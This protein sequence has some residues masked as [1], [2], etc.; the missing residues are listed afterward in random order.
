MRTAL[1]RLPHVSL[2]A[3]SLVLA[4]GG[5][6]NAK[7]DWQIGHGPFVSASDVRP[8]NKMPLDIRDVNAALAAEQ[9]DWRAAL[10]SFAFGGNFANHSLAIFTDN[11]NNRFPQHLPVS[12]GHFGDPGFQNHVLTAAIVGTGKFR[13]VEPAERVAFIEAGL[14]AVTINWSRYELGES[15][16]K[17][18]AAE[19]NWSLEN[20]SPKNWNEIFA[21]Y[22]GPEGEHSAH[23]AVERREGGA[24]INEALLQALADGQE[25]LVTESWTPEHAE[26]VARHLNEASVL[27][28]ADA[29]KQ[30]LDAGEGESAVARARAAGYWLAAAEAVAGNPEAA[31]A[32]EAALAP[33]STADDVRGAIRA[34]A[35]AG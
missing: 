29:L 4:C 1:L 18:T 30:A 13:S 26:A 11:Y 19:P 28:L 35:P 17:A 23:A 31:A 24:G 34:I 32:V 21:F 27:L 7:E 12:T 10:A 20:G 15:R 14:E 8:H 25:V 6:A 9:P 2:I 3:A 33:G 16:R 5:L 22:W